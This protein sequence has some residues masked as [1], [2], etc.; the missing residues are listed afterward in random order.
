VG[1]HDADVPPAAGGEPGRRRGG[2]V[3]QVTRGGLGPGDIALFDPESGAN[4]TVGG[5][6]A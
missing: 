4:L 2:D 1:H 5:S 3:A 6:A